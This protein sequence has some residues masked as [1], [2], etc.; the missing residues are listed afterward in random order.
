MAKFSMKKGGKEVGPASTYAAPH[1]NPKVSGRPV[2]SGEKTKSTRVNGPQPSTIADAD[3]NYKT[4]PNTMRADEST[5][6][7][8]PARRVAIGNMTREPKSTGIK[9]R[10]AGAATKGVMCRGPMA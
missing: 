8:M 6:G 2:P 4:D 1:H 7:G 10:G 9:M 3:I 5:P